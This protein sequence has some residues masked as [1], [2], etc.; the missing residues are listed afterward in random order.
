MATEYG[1]KHLSPGTRSMLAR[2]E[3]AIREYE[4]AFALAPFDCNDEKDAYNFAKRGM[5]RRLRRLEGTLRPD[6]RGRERQ[7][8][9]EAPAVE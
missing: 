5:I 9:E 2:Y 7:K 6:K 1:V 8:R 3:K 4:R